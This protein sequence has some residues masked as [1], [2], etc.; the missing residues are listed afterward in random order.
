M[1]LFLSEPFAMNQEG[2]TGPNKAEAK[3]CFHF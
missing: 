3:F 2:D 1:D